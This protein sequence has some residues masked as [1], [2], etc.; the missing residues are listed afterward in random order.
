MAKGMQRDPEWQLVRELSEWEP[1][2]GV[3]SVYF[4][5]DP[6]DRSEGWRI[7]LRDELDDYPAPV[8]KRVLDRY[9]EGQPH[10]SGRTQ[11]GFLDADGERELWTTTQTPL[12]RMSVVHAPRPYLTPLVRLLDEGGPF[13]VVAASL[14]RVRVFEWALGSID[15]LDG[16][17]LEITSLDWRERKS[18]HRDPGASGTGTTAAG[19]DQYEQRLDHNRARFLKQAGELIAGRYGER[20]W[21]RIV[22]I[23]DGDRPQLL[24]K[25]LGPKAGLV[26]AVPHDLIGA[27][28]AQIGERVAEELE[29]LNRQREEQL[30]E[31]IE[32]AIGAKPG[33]AVGQ[34]E[35]LRALQMAQAHHVIFDAEYDFEPIDGLPPTEQFILMALATGA[36][37]TPAEGLAAA[38]LRQR[39]G[40][41]A[42]LRFGREAQNEG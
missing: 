13:G 32:E 31:R 40:V 41:A 6:G 33:A 23:G 34:D 7:A 2:G 15:E 26:H 17:E 37:V 19:H 10:P 30:V 39:G 8:V 24:A 27:S 18:P 25:G 3:L 21:Q 35:V 29:H 22:L 28:A 36:E 14:E 38:S 5:I 1:A 42:L 16:W 20:P 11:I 9:R 4:E 12:D